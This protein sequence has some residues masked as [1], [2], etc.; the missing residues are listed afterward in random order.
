MTIDMVIG[1]LNTGNEKAS[2][3]AFMMLLLLYIFGYCCLLRKESK[4]NE[5]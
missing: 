3:I 2:T 1:S 5:K 4:V